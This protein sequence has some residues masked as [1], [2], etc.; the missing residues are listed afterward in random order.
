MVVRGSI[1]YDM[2]VV[3]VVPSGGEVVVVVQVVPFRA[4]QAGEGQGGG[5]GLSDDKL[6][7]FSLKL[8]VEVRSEGQ[9]ELSTPVKVVEG[10]MGEVAGDGGSVPTDRYKYTPSTST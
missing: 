6:K 3:V 1:Q 5:D 9:G 8:Q 10:L 7:K 4:H 2:N